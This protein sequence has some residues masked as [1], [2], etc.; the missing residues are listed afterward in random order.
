MRQSSMLQLRAIVC[1]ERGIIGNVANPPPG[2]G[3]RVQTVA[4]IMQ[5]QSGPLAVITIKNTGQTPAYDV[6]HW[7]RISIQEYPLKSELPT[8]PAL[9]KQ[10][11]SVLGPSI[12]AEKTVR[13]PN[14]LT[15]A[16]IKGLRDSTMA[17]YCHGEIHYRDAFK[18]VRLTRY[19]C[20]YCAI[21]GIE[22]GTSTDLTLCE[23]GNEAT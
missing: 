23:D 9:N 16:Q 20:M 11:R 1:V 17:I 5:P 3:E 13:L 22:I 2:P 10:F 21:T 14:A 12:V 7:G 8:M 15:E 6:L 18:K 19:R 4:R